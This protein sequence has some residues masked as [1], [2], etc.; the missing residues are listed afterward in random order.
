MSDMNRTTI[1]RNAQLVLNV[2]GNNKEWTLP[3]LRSATGLTDRDLCMAIGWLANDGDV[4]FGNNHEECSLS[5]G[6]N[7]FIG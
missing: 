3:D 6:I 1:R 5:S 7:V 4:C 2:L